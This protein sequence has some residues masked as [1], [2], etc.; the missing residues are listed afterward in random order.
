MLFRVYDD[1]YFLI[2]KYSPYKNGEGPPRLDPTKRAVLSA[3][4]NHSGA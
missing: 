4:R 1:I 2:D 3:E